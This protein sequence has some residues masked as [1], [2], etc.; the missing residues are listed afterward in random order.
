VDD[1]KSDRRV[2][3]AVDHDL[4]RMPARRCRESLTDRLQR[5]GHEPALVGVVSDVWA[6]LKATI[7][8][9]ELATVGPEHPNRKFVGKPSLV[10]GH[11][12]HQ[13]K[14][15]PQRG[16]ELFTPKPGNASR[17]DDE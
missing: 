1:L 13:R 3:L 15:H 9:H 17:D 2:G 8:S 5:E 14:R 16:R 12:D 6:D 4:D 10:R 7:H 11:F